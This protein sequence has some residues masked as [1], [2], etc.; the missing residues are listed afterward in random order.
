MKARTI[1][2]HPMRLMYD[3]VTPYWLQ[4]FERSRSNYIGTVYNGV[5]WFGGRSY[6]MGR[7]AA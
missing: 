2:T 3:A 5:M 6:E 7:R 1:W 4:L